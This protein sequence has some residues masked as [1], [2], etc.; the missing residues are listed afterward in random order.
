MFKPE[1][2]AALAD[3]HFPFKKFNPHQR[4]AILE[5]C[6]HFA[7]GIK[8]VILSAPTGIGKSAIATT[9][10]RVLKEH[11]K[12]RFRTTIVT[13][14]L[15]LQDQYTEIDKEV[16][17]L[18]GK[19]NYGCVNGAGN[20]GTPKCKQLVA[21]GNCNPIAVCTY[22]KRR[23][24]WCETADLRLTNTAFQINAGDKLVLE[25]ETRANMIVID[26]CHSL[27]QSLVNQSTAVI[28][29][30]ELSAVQK[31]CGKATVALFADFINLFLDY[32]I[33]NSLFLTDDQRSSAEKIIATITTTIRD[34]EETFKTA[35]KGREGI[36]HA[37]EELT[38]I[39][40]Q[41]KLFSDK[42]V[43]WI[44]TDFAFGNLVALKPVYAY[45][46]SDQGIFRKA[47]LFLHMSATVCG[48]EE[49]LKVNGIDSK[50]AKFIDV[51]NPIPIDNRKIFNLRAMKVSGQFDRTRLSGFIDKVIKRHDDENGIIH[52]VS[53]QLAKEISEN[54]VYSSRMILSSD[55]EEINTALKKHNSG[56]I[57]VSPSIETGYDF[58]G[59][60]SRWQ[61]I[62]KVPYLHL[63][64]PWVK[65][66]MERNSE[67]YA[68]TA[69]L[70]LVQ[71]SGRSVRGIDDWAMT[72][73]LDE[74]LVRLL[75]FNKKIFPKWYL[76]AIVER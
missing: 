54:S 43:E 10:H 51:P 37:I 5:I 26:E 64:D 44:L 7:N 6:S 23:K 4:E 56:K 15:G 25:E 76:D 65:L 18:R 58:P 19:T 68:R 72:Y 29:V 57:I 38:G 59:D 74:N 69:I 70:R 67:W 50:T 49:Y 35:T 9:V 2:F 71:A 16:Y 47:D 42:T 61:I 60:T 62:A 53:Y 73:V 1:Y 22:F 3:K 8:H 17:D 75:K 46:V 12:T 36:A 48:Y 32:E 41:F 13:S 20:Y 39:V 28:D 33:G 34:L 52:T 63:G 14:T 66:N 30:K 40:S 31:Q 24:N 11:R 45:S 27:E 55:P 21:E